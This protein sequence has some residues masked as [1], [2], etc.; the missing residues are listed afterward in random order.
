MMVTASWSL[1]A[2]TVPWLGRSLVAD[3]P[4]QRT[5]FSLV[6]IHVGY[7]VDEGAIFPSVVAVIRW[8]NSP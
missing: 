7:A 8:T 5:G 3:I 1:V 6:V 2:M 4:P